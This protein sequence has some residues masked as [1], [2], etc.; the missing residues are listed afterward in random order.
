MSIWLLLP[1]KQENFILLMI[2]V[3]IKLKYMSKLFISTGSFVSR[4]GVG[5][6]NEMDNCDNF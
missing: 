6:Y 4:L 5:L 1:G 2:V 3:I